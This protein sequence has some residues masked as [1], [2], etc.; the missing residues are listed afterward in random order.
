MGTSITMQDENKINT[1][2]TIKE[3]LLGRVSSTEN[4]PN[5][6]GLS[7]YTILGMEKP[8]EADKEA[9][10]EIQSFIE[11]TCGSLWAFRLVAIID[12]PKCEIYRPPYVIEHAKLVNK[13]FSKFTGIISKKSNMLG[14]MLRKISHGDTDV[15]L[16]ISN[17]LRKDDTS[18]LTKLLKKYLVSTSPIFITEHFEEEIYKSVDNFEQYILVENK[19]S[20]KDVLCDYIEHLY[21]IKTPYLRLDERR[22]FIKMLMSLGCFP[23]SK[24][25]KHDW[26][27]A[28]TTKTGWFEGSESCEYFRDRIKL[29]Y[30]CL[31]YEQFKQFRYIVSLSTGAS[32]EELRYSRASIMMLSYLISRSIKNN[33]QWEEIEGQT[34]LDDKQTENLVGFKIADILLLNSN[35][36][37]TNTLKW[38]MKQGY[39]TLKSIIEALYSG[40]LRFKGTESYNTLSD[41]A[42]EFEYIPTF[43]SFINTMNHFGIV[44][45]LKNYHENSKEEDTM[46]KRY[47]ILGYTQEWL[48]TSA[49]LLDEPFKS[50]LTNVERR[51]LGGSVSN[52]PVSRIILLYNMGTY[53]KKNQY[54]LA[55]KFRDIVNKMGYGEL[56]T[57]NY[58]LQR[59]NS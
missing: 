48:L 31:G 22:R 27:K 44:E 58:E 37:Y 54:L 6:D 32:N 4:T 41:S 36:S 42:E 43:T 45:L 17:L 28:D 34:A 51:I 35:N 8:N 23:S 9:I 50:G 40:E 25:Q 21:N 24:Q 10:Q 16:N 7:L 18:L 49:T 46:R 52:T 39:E 14:D 33:T 19:E 2:N 30:D 3:L 38:V 12:N 1:I 29:M 11:R 20:Y 59:I 57:Y 15:V 56:L 55:L 53:T 47:S 26:E 5:I 13:T